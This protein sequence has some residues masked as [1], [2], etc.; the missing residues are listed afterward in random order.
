MTFGV[1]RP[2]EW[3]INGVCWCDD[4]QVLFPFMKTG[5]EW[6]KMWRCWWGWSF[7]VVGIWVYLDYSLQAMRKVKVQPSF[8][9][10]KG[11]L[12]SKSRIQQENETTCDYM[13]PPGGHKS[14]SHREAWWKNTACNFNYIQVRS[15]DPV[16]AKLLPAHTGNPF[17]TTGSFTLW[18]LEK[19]PFWTIMKRKTPKK[20]TQLQLHYTFFLSK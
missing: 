12:R 9:F 1:V 20:K 3:I 4:M 17:L 13:V 8:S 16:E 6:L 19:Q 14:D 5:I 15:R 11:C 10:Y 2:C 18:M 7:G